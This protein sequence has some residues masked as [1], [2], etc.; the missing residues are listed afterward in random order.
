MKARFVEQSLPHGDLGD[1]AEEKQQ[2]RGRSGK[3]SSPAPTGRGSKSRTSS[4]T[5]GATAGGARKQAVQHFGDELPGAGGEVVSTVAG[6]NAFSAQGGIGSKGRAADLF[7]QVPA[8]ELDPSA[9]APPSTPGHGGHY[10]NRVE[11]GRR[12]TVDRPA[13]GQPSP[14]TSMTDGRDD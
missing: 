13:P 5:K 14:F 12:Q 3:K 2:E 9:G 11:E 7:V 4:P 1:F 6:L 8:L 10:E